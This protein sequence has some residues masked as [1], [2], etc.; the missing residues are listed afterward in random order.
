VALV[1]AN[2]LLVADD[3]SRHGCQHAAAAAECR[4]SRCRRLTDSMLTTDQ[5][6][7]VL[8]VWTVAHRHF[9]P[10][11]YLV[12]SM[13]RTTLDV[14]RNTFSDPLP[15]TDDLQTENLLLGNLHEGTRW[16]I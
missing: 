13:P 1:H 16:P 11:R 12:V 9:A 15:Q 3:S 8:C 2:A 6:H 7:T 4:H 14:A 10:A 5:L